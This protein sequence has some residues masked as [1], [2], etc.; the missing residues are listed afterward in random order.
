MP[1]NVFGENG[2]ILAQ[3]F[4]LEMLKKIFDTAREMEQLTA[5]NPL[6]GKILVSLFYE[7]STRTRLSFEI[8]HI[9]LGGQITGT[10]NAKEFSSALKGE[11]LED[12]VRIISSYRPDVIVL[13]Y[14][15]EGGAERA[16][17]FS[18]VPIINAGDGTGQHPTQSLLDLFTILKHFG[19]IENLNICL[20]GDLKNGRTVRSL[21]YFLA[22][23]FPK[24]RIIFVSPEQVRM[25]DDIKSYLA[26]YGMN[27]EET[28]DLQSVIRDAD[29][30][31]QTRVQK[32][33]FQENPSEYEDV[34][35]ASQRLWITPELTSKMK[36]GSIIMHPLPRVGEILYKVDDDPRAMYFQQAQ[37]GL[38]IRMALLKMLLA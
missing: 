23:H 14:H 11:S 33:R 35:A 19:R 10:E 25:R 15:K 12:T 32:E 4:T 1:A 30:V 2:I 3:Q 5:G 38:F 21:C 26:K 31:Y 24:N 22:K 20:A 9:K 16:Q 6:L 28:D 17:K 7:A 29:V 27:F 36:A 8:A 37:N 13:R 34:A 18:S